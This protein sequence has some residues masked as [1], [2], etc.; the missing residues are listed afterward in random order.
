[1]GARESKR[2]RER[3]R[4]REISASASQMKRERDTETL[5]RTRTDQKIEDWV[6]HR[7]ISTN[8]SRM[9]VLNTLLQL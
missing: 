3:E 2:E 6:V 1:M 7:D 5:T 9:D 4:E 8:D